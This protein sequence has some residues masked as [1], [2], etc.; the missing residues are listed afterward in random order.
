MLSLKKSWVFFFLWRQ[1]IWVQLFWSGWLPQPIQRCYPTTAWHGN[2][3]LLCFHP[4]PIRPSLYNL[5]TLA[6]AR[7]TILMPSLV[8]T[9]NRHRYMTIRT[10]ELKPSSKPGLKVARL[11]EC[12]T[13]PGR[14]TKLAQVIQWGRRTCFLWRKAGFFFLECKWFGFNYFVQAVCHN[15]FKGAIRLLLDM[16]TFACCVSTLGLYA[17]HY[18]TWWL[19]PLPETPYWCEA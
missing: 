7:D 15:L 14:Q 8:R 9:P 2:F 3:C 1:K 17:P 4:G 5:V 11:Q 12:T 16:G 13:T 6:S 10:P 18:T 19:Q